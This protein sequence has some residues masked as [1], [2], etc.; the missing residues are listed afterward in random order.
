MII[1]LY[2][3][4]YFGAGHDSSVIEYWAKREQTLDTSA[5]RNYQLGILMSNQGLV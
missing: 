3:L 2:I 5:T 1:P 4:D